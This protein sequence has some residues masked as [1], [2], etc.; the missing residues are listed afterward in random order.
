MDA[1]IPGSSCFGLLFNGA[2]RCED[3]FVCLTTLSTIWI[4]RGIGRNVRRQAVYCGID[5]SMGHLGR[6]C[7]HGRG[8]LATGLQTPPVRRCGASPWSLSSISRFSQCKTDSITRHLP[9]PSLQDITMLLYARDEILDR[10]WHCVPMA[11]SRVA[12]V[13]LSSP[14]RHPWGSWYHRILHLKHPSES[15]M[16]VRAYKRRTWDIIITHQLGNRNSVVLRTFHQTILQAGYHLK[17]HTINAMLTSL[18]IESNYKSQNQN[19]H[20]DIIAYSCVNV[21][22]AW[23]ASSPIRRIPLFS[24]VLTSGKSKKNLLMF[25]GA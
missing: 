13:E 2:R 5:R 17:K 23:S 24:R 6:R 4:Q 9:S 21:S 14:E 25:N 3:I 7:T 15:V 16:M 22:S 1:R 19:R 10:F 8:K 12:P 20:G 18:S 11:D